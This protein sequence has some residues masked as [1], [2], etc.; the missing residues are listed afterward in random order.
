M[1]RENQKIILVMRISRID[2]ERPIGI[3]TMKDLI[4]ELV[5]E[6]TEW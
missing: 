4:E 6:L 3:V 2:Q 1:R 5:G